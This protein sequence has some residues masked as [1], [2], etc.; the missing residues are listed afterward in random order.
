MRRRILLPLIVCL[1]TVVACS[2]TSRRL[3]HVTSPGSAIVPIVD[4]ALHV[5]PNWDG[6]ARI[7]LV[8]LLHDAKDGESVLERSD[9]GVLLD[10]AYHLGRIP[11]VLVVIPRGDPARK[12]R[13]GGSAAYRDWL[14][15]DLVPHIQG[16]YAV[17]ACPDGC[18]VMGVAQGGYGALRVALH[19]PQ[20]IASVTSISAP[21][22]R[23][24]LE[25]NE[26][27]V[28]WKRPADVGLTRLGLA[29]GR[30][31]RSRIIEDNVRFHEHL[32]ENRIPH[33]HLAFEGG[34]DWDSWGPAIEW[35]LRTLVAGAR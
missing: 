14:L 18:H 32:A 3:D 1:T 19:A 34:H 9:I 5:P 22:E 15:N 13:P 21:F 16:A 24:K 20:R 33:E 12:D 11:P 17:A 10:E 6:K 31:D 25:P 35:A 30:S 29:W 4:Y 8:L 2:P 26:F 7:P 27:Y 23:N 28:R